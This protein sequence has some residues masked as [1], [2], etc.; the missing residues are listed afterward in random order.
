VI[1]GEIKYAVSLTDGISAPAKAGSRSLSS[2]TKDL[3]TAK[4]ALSLYQGQLTRAK[5]LGDVEGYRKYSALVQDSKR[6][7]FDLTQAVE[8]AGAASSSLGPLA[9]AFGA[10][11]TAAAVT[12]GAIVGVG[13]A[14]GDMVSTALDVV[15]TN[16]RLKASFEALGGVGA[17]DK[18]LKFVDDLAHRLPQS[19]KEIAGWVTQFQALGITD[20]GQIREQVLATASAQ[21]I[22]FASGGQGA[23]VYTKLAERI[24]V[25]VEEHKG[26]KLADKQLKQLY[27]AGL[28]VTEIAAKMGLSTQ[29]LAAQLKAGTID[30]QTFGNALSTSLVEKGRGPLDA[31]G[32]S[33]GSLYTKAKETWAHLFDGLDTSPITNAIRSVIG[34]GDQGE[35]SGKA[36]KSGIQVGLQG[37]IDFVGK[38]ITEAEVL[39]LR[40][41]LYAVQNKPQ[42]LQIANAF[43]QI[44][45]AI[46]AT[47]AAL[48]KLISYVPSLQKFEE[49]IAA[50]SFGAIDVRAGPAV[51]A[52][53]GSAGAKAAPA[54][55][56]GGLVMQPA[57]GE[58]F[59]SV[60][61]GERILPRGESGGV[62]IEQL[63]I[64][65]A[66]KDGVTDANTL[67]ITAIS[68][69]LERLQIASGR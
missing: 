48:G 44:G 54:H 51:A 57:A 55:A 41:E 49:V 36:L 34:L 46:V 2:L 7:V 69:G 65:I 37:V 47:T 45:D 56:S 23:E 11:A 21:A 62:K 38:M 53:A 28:N 17:G 10:V 16:K 32:D 66:A 61:P 40:L 63:V 60:Q 33:L 50:E 52:G 24:H 27:E 58:L 30:A 39:F 43:G 13:V 14:L 22:T 12:V 42:L 20:L 15:D 19:R 6:Q 64:H 68:D 59:A 18:T 25:A 29:A 26:L 8:G 67:S 5:A 1:A 9:G 4:A 31:M 3:G 35:P